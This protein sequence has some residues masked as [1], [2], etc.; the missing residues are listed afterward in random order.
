MFK[1]KKK[2]IDLEDARHLK[3]YNFLKILDIRIYNAQ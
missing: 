1:N 2:Y 3:C